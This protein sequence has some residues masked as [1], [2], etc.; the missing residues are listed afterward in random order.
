MEMVQK[1]TDKWKKTHKNMGKGYRK[2]QEKHD[3][4]KN[5]NLVKQ[6]REKQW[7]HQS[8]HKNENTEPPLNY[9]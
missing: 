2:G 9:I 3:D 6:R 5:G 1:M 8:V 7:K 4:M